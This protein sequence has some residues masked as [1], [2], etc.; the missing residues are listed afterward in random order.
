MR[1]DRV[2][3]ADVVRLD[4]RVGTEPVARPEQ[5]R[6]TVLKSFVNPEKRWYVKAKI[7]LRPRKSAQRIS[8]AVY[9]L[10][11][12]GGGTPVPWLCLTTATKDCAADGQVLVVA[13]GVREV[14]FEGVTDEDK[15][16]VPAADSCVTVDIKKSVELPEV[17]R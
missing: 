10:A 6:V 3:L 14:H 7:R 11:E 8:P 1:H 16:P 15:H 5:P 12:S 4:G 13:A 9:F 17:A 2:E